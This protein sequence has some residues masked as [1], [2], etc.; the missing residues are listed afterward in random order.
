MSLLPPLWTQSG[1]EYIMKQSILSILAALITSTKSSSQR[2]HQL[3]L[4]LIQSSLDPESP[5]RLYL[6]EDAL[7]LWTSILAETPTSSPELL[8]LIPLLLPLLEN[9]TPILRVAI[10]ILES[11]LLLAPSHILS[12]SQGLSPLLSSLLANNPK[13]EPAGL[14]CHLLELLIQSATLVGGPPAIDILV[15]SLSTPLLSTLTS[16][17]H[18][19]YLAHQTTGPNRTLSSIDGIVETDHLAVLARIALASPEAFVQAMQIVAATITPQA[20][21]HYSS[22][23]FFEDLISWLLTEW[24]AHLDNIGN[25]ERK[26]LMCLAL[27]RLLRFAQPWILLHLQELM[28]MWTD[29]VVE[30]I[31]LSPPED[32]DNG[33]GLSKGLGRDCLVWR[34]EVMASMG[35]Q[36]GESVEEGRK[37]EMAC[38]D[39]VHRVD[40]REVI[41]SELVAVVAACGGE[42]AFQREWVGNVDEDVVKAFGGLGIL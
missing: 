32:E 23:S 3:V 6:L 9:L 41:R 31:E 30:V 20:A 15:R 27:T 21:Q 26:K 38:R 36:Q 16:N 11:Y 13:P 29:V 22:P 35:Q 25:P 19:A 28:T 24:F 10:H 5:S 2:Y 12:L 18:S 33:G 39:E 37:R 34:A 7:D 4:P 17:L 42:E 40:V 8:S 1:E 14:V